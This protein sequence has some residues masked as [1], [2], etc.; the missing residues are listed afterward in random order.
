MEENS[1]DKPV[2]PDRGDLESS[3]APNSFEGGSLVDLDQ[4][5]TSLLTDASIK[6]E[7]GRKLRLLVKHVEFRI[8]LV[9]MSAGTKWEDHKTNARILF[10]PLRGHMR[11]HT[12]NRTFDVNPGQF[13]TLDPG[14]VH[15]VSSREASAFLLTLSSANQ[16]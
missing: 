15:S 7:A 6:E 12:P 9:T 10:Q 16:P 13:M 5:L 8:V 3:T 4:E 14:I 1:S 2:I 11:F